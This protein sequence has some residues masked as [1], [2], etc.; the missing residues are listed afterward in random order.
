LVVATHGF[1]KKHGKVPDNEIKKTIQL[2]IKYFED[3]EKSK[4]K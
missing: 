4:K 1:I 3:K 2:R